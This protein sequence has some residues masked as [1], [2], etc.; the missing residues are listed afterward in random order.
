[1]E[2]IIEQLAANMG[3]YTS[4]SFTRSTELRSI[5][6]NLM[7][8]SSATGCVQFSVLSAD[9]SGIDAETE[10]NDSWNGVAIL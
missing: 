8:V 9:F 4:G 3:I 5:L 6:S 10:G 7:P 2:P 1:M